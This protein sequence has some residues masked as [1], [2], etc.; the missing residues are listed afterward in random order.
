VSLCA[1]ELQRCVAAKDMR[2][3]NH[4]R[5]IYGNEHAT[6][7]GRQAGIA[8]AVFVLNGVQ[9]QL[10]LHRTVGMN[11]QHKAANKAECRLLHAGVGQA[12]QG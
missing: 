8:A 4:I 12:C 7:L 11:G 1:I 9:L 3:N 6:C 10:P 2:G 5:L